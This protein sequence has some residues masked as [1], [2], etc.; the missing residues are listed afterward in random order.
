MG[1]SL[2]SNTNIAWATTLCG[3]TLYIVVEVTSAL[4]PS[5]FRLLLAHKVSIHVSSIQNRDLSVTYFHVSSSYHRIFPHNIDIYTLFV[6]EQK[7]K[8]CLQK[9]SHW[10]C[11][12]VYIST[13][14]LFEHY[15]CVGVTVCPRCESNSENSRWYVVCAWFSFFVDYLHKLLYKQVL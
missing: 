15:C 8:W 11:M 14:E 7:L 9:E 13:D 4:R 1:K 3:S 6:S 2:S 5:E 12:I 10:L